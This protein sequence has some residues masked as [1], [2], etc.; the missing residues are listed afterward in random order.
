MTSKSRTEYQSFKFSSQ[1]THLSSSVSLAQYLLLSSRKPNAD[2]EF[3]GCDA[4][5]TAGNLQR[6]PRGSE[7]PLSAVG[8]MLKG[9][10]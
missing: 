3:I 5:G 10:S 1:S 2:N 4:S 8:D 7:T 9:W 6:D